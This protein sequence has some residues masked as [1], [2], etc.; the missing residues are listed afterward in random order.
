[1]SE[2]IEQKLLEMESPRLVEIILAA[3]DTME[4]AKQINF[5]AEHIDAQISLTRLGADDPE[6]FLDEVEAFCLDCL[7]EVYYSDEDDIDEYFL[8][9]NNDY[10]YSYY[11]DWDDGEYY[12]NSEW[13]KKFTQLFKLSA[14]YIQ[15]GDIATGYE[16]N[17]RLLS[18][19]N[20][21]SS[22]DGFL[23]TDN[24]RDY[25]SVDWEKLFTLHYDALFQYHTNTEEAIEK[26]FRC[27]VN[28]GEPC[29]EG[30]LSNVKDLPIGERII[31]AGLKESPYW[32]FQSL[33]FDLL[34]R[35]YARLDKA[36]DKVSQAKALLNHNVYFSRFV[37]EG[38]CEEANWQSAI[39]AAL[40]ALEQIPMPLSDITDWGQRSIQQAIRAAIQAKL[41]DA[42]E[43]RGDFTQAFENAKGMFLEAPSFGLYIRARGLAE[44]SVGVSALLALVEK[45]LNGKQAGYGQSSL[46]RD[47]YSYEGEI[48]KLLDMAQSQSIDR[49]YYDRKY[50]ALSLIYR[51]VGGVPDVGEDLSE[52]LMSA[53]RQD[54]IVDMLKP[55]GDAV[56][57]GELLL[58][59]VDLL[60]TII[61]FHI[62]AAKRT[63]YA[64]AAYYM[65][66]MRD[67]YI[68]LQREDDFRHYFRGV[69]M[70]NSRRPALRDEMSIVYGK[71][72][73]G[74]K[75][76]SGR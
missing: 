18:C 55:V 43:N 7:N 45:R 13:A 4:E 48:Q 5:I 6:A 11:D 58:H 14:M 41:V 1:M 32:A 33:C 10:E 30:F 26:A 71:E 63:R 17:A 35:L 51:A 50:I 76:Q 53:Q 12:S 61:Q 3:L 65:C 60:R 74:V 20:T 70:E 68:Y 62:A 15:N 42:Y 52:Y 54:G 19:L 38:L 67:I 66:V 72:A 28:F 75:K 27:W 56:Q 36:F 73:T 23:G 57:Q 49:N 31:L 24:P 69:I 2:L 34:M 46:L 8:D 25:I 64:K 44:K 39:E 40:I 9:N 47:I 37:V 29:A 22:S 59:G 16:A 21:M